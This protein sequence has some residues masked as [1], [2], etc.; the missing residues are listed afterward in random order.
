MCGQ[1]S[2]SPLD[3]LYTSHLHH[4]EANHS[5]VVHDDRV[6]ALDEAHTCSDT[7]S[8]EQ[9][10]LGYLMGKLGVRMKQQHLLRHVNSAQA[11]QLPI[12]NCTLTTHVSCEIEDVVAALDDSLAI[13][14]YA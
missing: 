11:S 1:Q 13:L 2:S 6:I 7:T 3:A 4:V 12:L 9:G 10:S 8:L 14:I 5:V